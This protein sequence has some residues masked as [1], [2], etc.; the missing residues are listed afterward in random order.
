M[1][2]S[3]CVNIVKASAVVTCL[4]VA[5]GACLL[6]G[7]EARYDD[8]RNRHEE[9]HEEHHEDHHEERH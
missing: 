9:R 5:L 6:P 8:R 2:C 1:L 4:G 3:I 7:P